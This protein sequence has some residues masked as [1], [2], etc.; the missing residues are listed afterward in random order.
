MKKILFLF[1]SLA[2]ASCAT[3][4]NDV[5]T[6]VK[7]EEVYASHSTKYKYLVIAWRYKPSIRKYVV[8]TDSLYRKGSTIEFKEK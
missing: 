8:K 4:R 1:I 5:K 7:V 3:V 2:A 6:Q